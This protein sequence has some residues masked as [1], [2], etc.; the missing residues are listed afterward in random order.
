VGQEVH[1]SVH[2]TRR[3]SMQTQQRFDS[4]DGLSLQAAP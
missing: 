2:A 1:G 3:G 4:D